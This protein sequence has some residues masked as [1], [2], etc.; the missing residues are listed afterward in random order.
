MLF[1]L[2]GVCFALLPFC[3]SALEGVTG[4]SHSRGV[5]KRNYKVRYLT[6]VNFLLHF[7]LQGVRFMN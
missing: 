5:A 4:S 3:Y 1:V 2:L 6:L 7:E